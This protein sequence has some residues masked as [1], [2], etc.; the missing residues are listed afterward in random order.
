MGYAY[1]V[2]RENKDADEHI[3]ILNRGFQ[4]GHGNE[5]LQF[6]IQTM[7]FELQAYPIAGWNDT[8]K[9]IQIF[10]SI[11]AGLI[12]IAF[13]AYFI[14]H[15]QITL[16]ENA[17]KDSMTGLW[18]RLAGMRKINRRLKDKHFAKG[19]FLVLDIDHFK[20]VNDTLGHQ[21]GD[22]ILIECAKIFKAILR[23]NDI[24]CPGWR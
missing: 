4:E 20:N 19:A 9:D 11:F 2:F 23:T 13:G 8:H 10:L 16:K 18:N 15:R 1:R 17:T 7:N 24:V 22:E 12:M 6:S 5:T 14:V 21:A 3:E